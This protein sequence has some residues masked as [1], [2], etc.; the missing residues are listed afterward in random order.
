L[1]KE[2]VVSNIYY[3]VEYENDEFSFYVDPV[4]SNIWHEY[5]RDPLDDFYKLSYPEKEY[6]NLPIKMSM[7]DVLVVKREVLAFIESIVSKRRPKTFKFVVADVNRL[8]IYLR[9]SE[10][11][12]EKYGYQFC[13]DYFHIW[14]YKLS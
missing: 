8:I 1:K 6:G 2:F 12:A 14:F 4:K 13:F 10:K 3:V 7:H 5:E 9:L 11:L